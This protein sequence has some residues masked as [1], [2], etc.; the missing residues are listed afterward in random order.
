MY[1]LKND[2]QELT[3][4]YDHPDYANKRVELMQLLKET[5]EQYEDRDPEERVHELFKGDRR[6]MKNR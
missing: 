5:Q 4:L 3:N 2:P 6:L 1:D